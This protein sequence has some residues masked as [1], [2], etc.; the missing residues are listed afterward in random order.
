MR[1]VWMLAACVALG[2]LGCDSS[3]VSDLAGSIKDAAT[4]GVS[5]VSEKAEQVAGSVTE[6]TREMTD[7]VSENLA[8]AGNMELTLDG[9]VKTKACYTRFIP[10]VAGRTSVLQ[11]QS[12]RDAEQQSFPSAFLRAQVSA[13]QLPEL[14]G[15]TVAAQLF[16]QPEADGTIWYTD[17]DLVQLKIVGVDE[18]QVTAELVEGSLLSTSGDAEQAVKGTFTGVI[19]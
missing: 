12:Y 10:S 3:K 15:Q 7:T 8:L 5:Q 6:T 16:V 19:Q 9:P 1:G 11:M 2:T 13:S 4:E 17:T 14:A 18:K